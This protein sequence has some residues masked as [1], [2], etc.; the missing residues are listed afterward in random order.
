M[1]AAWEST[2]LQG[3]ASIITVQFDDITGQNSVKDT[4]GFTASF[5]QKGQ[6]TVLRLQDKPIAQITESLCDDW[7]LPED[8]RLSV[9]PLMADPSLAVDTLLEA[10]YRK[11]EKL[12][13]EMDD[14][15]AQIK[16]TETKIMSLLKQQF[17]SCSSMKCLWDTAMSK[18]PTIAHLIVSHFT[19]HK[20]RIDGCTDGD[21]QTT[22][23][24]KDSQDALIDNKVSEAEKVAEAD[25]VHM[26]QFLDSLPTPP[27]PPNTPPSPFMTPLPPSSPADAE[28]NPAPQQENEHHRRPPWMDKDAPL[29]PPHGP[30]PGFPHYGPPGPEHRGAAFRFGSHARP[31]GHPGT[32]PFRAEADQSFE[33]RLGLSILSLLLL[34]IISAFLFRCIK[35]K[36]ARFRDPRRQAERAARREERRTRNLYRKAACKH[37]WSTWWNRLSRWQGTNDYE[38]KRELILEQEGISDD[39]MQK[40]IRTLRNAS[41]LVSDLIRAEEGRAR[42]EYDSYHH[43]VYVPAYSPAELDAGV[44]SSRLSDVA[45]SYVTPPPRYEE[46]FD[47]E[48]TVVDGFQY[49]PSTTDDTSAS[50][51]V[52]CSPR[53]SFETGRS[54]I[55]TKDARD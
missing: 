46:E 29:E 43:E 1:H 27:Q 18:V 37:K 40:E 9:I 26:D 53:L 12:K 34:V 6:P 21:A 49:T 39:V 30:P 7:L 54:T 48:L 50:S 41:D 13:M 24:S 25:E 19:Q 22:C 15:H 2:C 36:V 47:G 10:E 16:S 4:S 20:N 32:L 17:K 14:L 8:Q 44:G 35:H 51:I 33:Y 52:D 28:E 55:L 31:H 3:Q 42:P 45:P 5:K 38:E 11:F 23:S